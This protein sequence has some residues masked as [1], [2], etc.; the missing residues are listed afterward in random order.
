MKTKFLVSLFIVSIIATGCNKTVQ[1]NYTLKDTWGKNGDWGNSKAVKYADDPIKNER[2]STQNIKVA[3]KV[4][5]VIVPVKVVN[6]VATP[7]EKVKSEVKTVSSK[8]DNSYK[9]Q[10]KS[11]D[12]SKSYF[13]KTRGDENLNFSYDLLKNV[14]V[15]NKFKESYK[16]K[17]NSSFKSFEFISDKETTVKGKKAWEINYSFAQGAKVL[18]QKQVFIDQ[19]KNTMVASLV[20]TQ[21]GFSNLDEEFKSIAN[22][23][24][25]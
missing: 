12:N 7:K 13:V 19:N 24:K 23:L 17:L 2:K 10:K 11:Y 1:P 6:K 3:N 21:K 8:T 20:S 16:K 5:K 25:L 22:N 9:W 18:N 4:N 15:D 14:K